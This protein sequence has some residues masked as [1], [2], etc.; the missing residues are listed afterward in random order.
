MDRP[1]QWVLL[2]L[3]VL[4]VVAVST[5]SVM[6]LLAEAP[7]LAVAFYRLLFATLILAG[8]VLAFY[9]REIAG[10]FARDAVPLLLTGFVLALHFATW[11]TSLS[12][13]SVA[14]SLVLV[15]LH[16]AI[17]GGITQFYFKERLSGKAWW[18]IAGAM[19]GA[20]IIGV[21]D[22]GLGETNLIGDALAFTGGICAAL[23]F[24]AGRRLRQ[25][26]PLLA[27]AFVVYLACTVF[28]AIFMLAANT[29]FTGYSREQYLWFVALAVVPMI[30]GHTVINFLLKWV[31][32]PLVSTSILGEPIGSVILAF[33]VLSQVP[34]TTSVVGGIVILVCVYF[35]S[36]SLDKG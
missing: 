22:S 7:P 5:A 35:V 1:P 26:V 21:G 30:L 23:Y 14:S 9:R 32:A 6:I 10:I 18:G 27:Y 17:V 25:R 2:S 19:V 13:T 24:I 12:L 29:P 34:P 16:P 33:V 20:G 8:P 28:L 11:I 4:S 3:L 15:T 36:R 31:P